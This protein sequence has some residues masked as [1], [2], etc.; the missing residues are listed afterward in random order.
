M[1]KEKRVSEGEM[2][3][4]HHQC[5]RHEVGQ[6]SGDGEG[7][8]GLAHCSPW[9]RKESDMTGHWTTTT[10]KKLKIIHTEWVIIPETHITH[11]KF[12]SQIF[13]EQEQIDKKKQDNTIEQKG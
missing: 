13:N 11:S 4:W 5:N 3:G 9:G 8:R 1:Q 7:Q 6:T 10:A 2:T 12:I